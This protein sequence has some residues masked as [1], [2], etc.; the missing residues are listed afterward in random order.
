[1]DL[2]INGKNAPLCGSSRGLGKACALA[3]AHEGVNVTING[4]DGDR[5][6]AAAQEIRD[7]T[8]VI[9]TAVQADQSTKDGRA[10]LLS[11]CPNPD[12]LVNNNSGPPPRDF[13]E[14]SHDDYIQIK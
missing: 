2:G 4:L 13:R 12:I 14:C 6:E 1:M 3:L 11:A 7:A 5:L 8:G 9:V 10:K